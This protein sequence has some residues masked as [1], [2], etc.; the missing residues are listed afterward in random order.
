MVGAGA[1][2]IAIAREFVG[3]KTQVLLL[4]SGGL[5]HEAE[6]D[7]LKRGEVDGLSPDG[8]IGGRGR[9]LGGTTTLWAG[10]CIPL[11]EIDFMRRD[12]VSH[13]GWPIAASEL[14]PYYERAASLL[15][16]AGEAHDETLWGRWGLEPPAL[17]RAKL[18][19]NYTVWSP[20]PD[21]GRSYRRGLQRS[22]N[23]RVLL[24]ANVTAIELSPGKNAFDQLV[25]RSLNGSS[26]RVRARACVLCCGAVENARLL[27]ISGDPENG[28][29]GNAYGNVGRFFQDHP[30]A[31]CAVLRTARPRALQ[32]PYSLFYRRGRR[33]LPK[34][35]LAP[36]VQRSERVLNCGANLEYEFA[37]EGLNALRRIYRSARQKQQISAS[38]RDLRLLMRVAPVAARTAYRRLVAGRA[39]AA[40][41]AKIWLQTH[42]EQGPN[43]E[44]RVCLS[45][46]R[47]AL[48]TNLPRVEWR[49]TDLERRTAEVMA[50]TVA[51]EF[52]RLGLA[53]AEI[54]G[55][56]VDSGARW[57]E[58]LEDSYHHIGTTRMTDDREQ[59]VVDRDS[60]VHGVNGLYVSGSSVFPTSGFANP[61]LTLVALALRLSDHLR[62]QLAAGV[63][64]A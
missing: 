9:G 33:Y 36:E 57:A 14:S 60:Q 6:T 11:E 44:S 55:W 25:V 2:G 1:A 20:R 46:E 53:E 50:R 29:L 45:R 23:V 56:L 59:G 18:R 27:L 21:L 30:N 8:L 49:V 35:T 17:D 47:D 40:L 13:S 5:G 10:Q 34:L 42:S 37:D 61:T 4:E 3:S 16:V 32:E 43:P 58:R 51:A 31:N 62:R 52:E 24:H 15:A 22:D 39:S 63:V 41:P 48:G 38:T 12:W 19:H 7:Q 26:A 64:S 28:G 54:P